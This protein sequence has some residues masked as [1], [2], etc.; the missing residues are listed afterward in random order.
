MSEQEIWRDVPYPPGLQASSLGRLRVVPFF[1]VMPYGGLRKYGGEPTVGIW[2]GNR[3]IYGRK[4]KTYKVA[5]LVCA[6]FHG[7]APADKPVC[8]H[9]NEN[10]RDN[11]P[12]NLRWGTQKENLNMPKFKM[13]LRMRPNPR[14]V[15]RQRRE[16]A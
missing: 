2:D 12:E 4:G 7:P 10:S 9:L 15:A 6:A 16:A 8:M 5:R 13:Y 3:Y 1:G 14:F 11:R